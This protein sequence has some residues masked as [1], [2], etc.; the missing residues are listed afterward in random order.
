MEQRTLKVSW[1]RELVL[2]LE[3]DLS[4]AHFHLYEVSHGGS[5]VSPTDFDPV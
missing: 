2:R 5:D 4:R 1:A 3:G